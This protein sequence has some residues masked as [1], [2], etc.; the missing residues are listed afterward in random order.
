MEP[1]RGVRPLF[2]LPLRTAARAHADADEELDSFVAARIDWLVARG[3]HPTDARAE[4]LRRLGGA[5]IDDVRATLHHSAALREERMRSH[6]RLETLRHDIRFALRRMAAE[7]TFALFA[8]LIV[9]LG[10]A[11]TTAVFSVVNP[12]MLRPLPFRDPGRLVWIASGTS[13]GLSGVTSRTSNLRDYRAQARSFEALTGYFAFFEYE[14]FNL[15]GDGAPERLVGVGVAQDFLSVLGVRPQLGR[16]FVAEEGVWH[17]RPAAILTHGFWT[18]RFAADP[19]VVGRAIT[20]NGVPTTV[21]GVLPKSFDFAST[22]APASRVDFLRP[23]PISDE[24]DQWGNTLAIIGRLRPGVSLRAAQTELDVVDERLKRADPARWG[25]VAHVSGLQE[26]ITGGLRS[27]LLLLAAGAAL[28]LLVACA[29]LSNLL[30]ARAQRRAREMAVRSAL[31]ASR[32]RLVRQ[33]LVESVTLAAVGGA[34][35]VALAV[36]ITRAVAS[37]SA[38][39]IPLLGSVAVDARA[40]AFTVVVTLLTGIVVGVVP[41]LQAARGGEAMTL[42]DA[43]RGASDGR[44]RARLREGLVVVEMAVACL[45]LVGGGLLLR[46]FV[47]VLHVDLGFR[48]D[49]AV[50]W[51]LNPGRDFTGD[52][53]AAFYA[54]LTARVA[55]VPGVQSVGLTDTPPLGR[56]RSWTLTPE[57][58]VLR[59][60]DESFTIF[61]RLVDEHYLQ[62]M[63]IPLVAGRLFTADDG[64]KAPRVM[65]LNRT[66]AATLFP[67][68]DPIGRIVRMQDDRWR[69]V[70]VVGDVRHQALEQEAGL[71]MYLPY[72]QHPDFGGL[73][74][75][76]R[77][78]LPAPSIASGVAAA[79][80]ATDPAMPA[81]DWQPLGAVVDRALSPRRFI[82]TILAAFAGV[83][84]LLAALGTY[85]VLS[86]TV[87]QRVREIGIRMALGESAERVR[88]RV[89]ARTLT[90]A[91]AGIAV[92]STAAFLLAHLIGSLLYGIPTTDAPTFAATAGLLLAAAA[93]AGDVPARR[94]SG[95]DPILAVRGV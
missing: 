46:S 85:A 40:A 38:V 62:T 65:I 27:A 17:G 53:G 47:R 58:E 34:I 8:A 77:T 16:N 15:V 86:Y 33:L 79:L 35:G 43:D 70:G 6:E 18:R 59:E 66:A 2:R 39:R 31:G 36:A 91:A 50:A 94:A 55:A 63:R 73:T 7:K 19:H 81:A 76:V 67:G 84:L 13:G 21:V 28:V 32:A 45:L 72:V 12:L 42:R 93:I 11:A 69:V 68:K 44:G 87:S 30:L 60:K 90:L 37:T 54:A 48:P 29:N 61:P 83:A 20:L 4:A 5:T 14:S 1:R 10:V 82:L 64:A 95:T 41:A 74:M 23:F 80:H 52:Q 71:E 57:G 75:V 22:F 26:H 56:N 88:R 9:A 51:Q 24:T 92:G 49:G 89:V 25:L 78:S 3:M